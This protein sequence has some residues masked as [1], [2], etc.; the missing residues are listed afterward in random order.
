MP[1]LLSRGL[2][3]GQVQFQHIHARLAEEA[4]LAAFGVR[5]YK[6]ANTLCAHAARSGYAGN[7]H[8]GRSGTDVRVQAAS[9]CG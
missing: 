8:V 9:R 4:V 5:G 6:L 1:Y 2:V 7:L 3:Q